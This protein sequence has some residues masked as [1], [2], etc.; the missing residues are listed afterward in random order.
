VQK[1]TELGITRIVLLQSERSVVRWDSERARKHLLRLEAVAG[2][3][4]GQ[5]RGV[6]LPAITG[7]VTPEKFLADERGLGRT[8]AAASFGGTRSWANTDSVLIGPEGGWS[9]AELASFG[10][11]TIAFGDS[12]LRAETAAIAAGV[13]LMARS[14]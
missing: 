13:L 1:L 10:D 12:V 5:S 7:P 3:A 2:E 14:V 11:N 4:L 9:P 6:W 8:V